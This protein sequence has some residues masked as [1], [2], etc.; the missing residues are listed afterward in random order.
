MR[1]VKWIFLIIVAVL[2]IPSRLS[3]RKEGLKWQA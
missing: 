1:K 3:S 2:L